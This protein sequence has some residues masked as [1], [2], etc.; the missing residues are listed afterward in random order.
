[1]YHIRGERIDS[2]LARWDLARDTAERVGAG[3]D[4]FFSLTVKLLQ[5]L[6]A[7]GHVVRDLF[8]ELGGNFPKNQGE[9][10]EFVGRLR[11][12]YHFSEHFPGSINDA[13]HPVDDTTMSIVAAII[14]D[15][16][17]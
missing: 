8:R 5:K 4:N 3:V 17:F 11:L 15:M 7:P 10:D 14:N 6:G 2:V 13:L 12:H 9:Y 16:D 1:M